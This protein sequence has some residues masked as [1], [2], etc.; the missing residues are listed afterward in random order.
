MV[1]HLAGKNE[2]QFGADKQPDS[3]LQHVVP[4]RFAA[5]HLK[6]DLF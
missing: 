1:Y 5:G 6:S 4:A 2:F 3:A